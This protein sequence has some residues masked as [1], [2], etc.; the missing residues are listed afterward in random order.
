MYV[1]CSDV[2]VIKGKRKEN[3]IFIANR[4]A[5]N[6]DKNGYTS[7]MPLCKSCLQF[8]L[9]IKKDL[10][11]NLNYELQRNPVL[12]QI[13]KLKPPNVSTQVIISEKSSLRYQ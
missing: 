6:F 7:A 13:L 11:S 8:A 1:L 9:Q 3:V 10:L 12:R 5:K 4:K 2:I